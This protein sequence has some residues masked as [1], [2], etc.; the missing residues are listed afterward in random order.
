MKYTPGEEETHRLDVSAAKSQSLHLHT[1]GDHGLLG[2]GH[3]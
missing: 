1:D 2:V 3:S